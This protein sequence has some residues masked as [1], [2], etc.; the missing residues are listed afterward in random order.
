[1][2]RE[3]FFFCTKEESTLFANI[4]VIEEISILVWGCC[5]YLVTLGTEGIDTTLGVVIAE[6]V[7]PFLSTH[8]YFGIKAFA[9][10]S[11][12]AVCLLHAKDFASAHYG[13]GVVHLEYIFHRYRK[14][15]GTLCY[16]L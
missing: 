15:I 16:N 13:T 6:D 8:C 7:Y 14:V 3:S 11:F 5:H 10:S 4:E 12:Y 2:L 9:K 1:M